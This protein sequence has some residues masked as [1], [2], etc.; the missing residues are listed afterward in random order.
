MASDG[1]RGIDEVAGEDPD[2]IAA[3][4][5]IERELDPKPTQVWPVT[6]EGVVLVR[7]GAVLKVGSR[8]P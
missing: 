1:P 2:V 5:A 4:E 7:R 8:L 6:S 3:M